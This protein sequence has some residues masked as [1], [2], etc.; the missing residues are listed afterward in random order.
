LK[1]KNKCEIIRTDDGR[2]FCSDKFLESP[3]NPGGVT[4][5]SSIKGSLAFALVNKQ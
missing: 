4:D 5:D 3:D 1:C 2:C